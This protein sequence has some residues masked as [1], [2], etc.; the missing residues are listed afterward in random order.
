VT[1]CPPTNLF[2]STLDQHRAPVRCEL[3]LP[4][5]RS[6]S[7]I[8][9]FTTPSGLVVGGAWVQDPAVEAIALN[10]D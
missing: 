10:G 6:K 3:V 7:V 8:E 9:R 5:S 1:R 4:R 2:A